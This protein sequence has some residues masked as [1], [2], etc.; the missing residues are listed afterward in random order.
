MGGW[1]GQELRK[2]LHGQHTEG[3]ANLRHPSVALS[4]VDHRSR[5]RA[6]GFCA[7]SIRGFNV[8]EGL[9]RLSSCLEAL[10]NNLLLSSVRF[11]VKFSSLGL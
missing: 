8:S 6:A 5:H 3:S 9:P 7:Q 11:L 10:E 2:K 4:F 1:A